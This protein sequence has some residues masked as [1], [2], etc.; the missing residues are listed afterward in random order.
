MKILAAFSLV[1]LSGC[2]AFSTQAKF[3]N[4]Q[5]YWVGHQLADP[6][7]EHMVE[8]SESSVSLGGGDVEYLYQYEE[9]KFTRVINTN[10][11]ILKSWAYEENSELCKISSCGAW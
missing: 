2:C 6:W 3:E 11:K 8:S 5:D 7:F 4:S 10:T 9:C 1:S